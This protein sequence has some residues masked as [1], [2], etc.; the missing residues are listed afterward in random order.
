M[1][2][3][4]KQALQNRRTCYA[5]GNT[6][7]ISDQ[8]L[9]EL[10]QVAVLNVPSA[11]NSQTA[12]LVLLLGKQH[13]TFWNIVKETLRKKVPADAFPKTE[14]KIDDSFA[15]GY[16]T[17]LYF[18]ET[19][20]VKELQQS[21]PSYAENFPTW[22]QQT[23]AMHQLAVWTLLEDAGFGASLQHYNPLIDSDVRKQWNLPETWQFIAQMPFG[24]PLQEPAP[25]EQQS[26]TERIKIFR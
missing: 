6:S 17:V 8:A 25:K 21:F 13:T 4:F 20:I 24:T 2:T 22:S 5:L 18:E 26:L 23:S 16:G 19:R 7:P 9:E 3:T 1:E 15:A 14:K 11:F 12:R 10:L